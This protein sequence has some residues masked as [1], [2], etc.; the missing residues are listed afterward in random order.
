MFSMWDVHNRGVIPSEKVVETLNALQCEG[1]EE[2]L[3]YGAEVD[4]ATF[5]KIVKQ[6]LEALFRV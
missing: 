5:M 1:T 4:R 2:A 3:Q 6:K